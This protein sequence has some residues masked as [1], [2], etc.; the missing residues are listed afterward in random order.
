[1]QKAVAMA[2]VER[3]SSAPVTELEVD[4][5]GKKSAARVVALPFYRRAK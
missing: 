1:L 4:V 2:Y 5:R 3:A